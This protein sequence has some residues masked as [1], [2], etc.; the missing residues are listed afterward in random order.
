MKEF[1][2]A[3]LRLPNEDFAAFADLCVF[4]PSI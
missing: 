1:A 4:A 2:I 3:G